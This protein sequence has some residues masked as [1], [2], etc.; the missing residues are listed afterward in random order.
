MI[1]LKLPSSNQDSFSEGLAS[2][3]TPSKQGSSS[4]ASANSL[5]SAGA[6]TTVS[7]EKTSSLRKTLDHR[8]QLVMQLF[9]DNGLFPSN[10]ERARQLAKNI[11]M[12]YASCFFHS[13]TLSH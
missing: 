3:T 4:G 12:I 9:Q 13:L 7:V 5:N 1:L 11:F 10:Q 8:R 6:A 2:P